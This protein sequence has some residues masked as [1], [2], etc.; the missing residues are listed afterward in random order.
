MAKTLRLPG[1][2]KF[3]LEKFHPD[4]YPEADER[5]R[6]L[7]T[8]ATQTITAAYALADELHASE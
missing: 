2:K 4:K 1:V 7:L 3:L 8:E 5:Q 6:A